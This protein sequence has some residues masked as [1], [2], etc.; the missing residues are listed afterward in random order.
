[1]TST[2]GSNFTLA[3]PYLRWA[4][5]GTAIP[6]LEVPYGTAW[7]GSWVEFTDTVSGLEVQNRNPRDPVFTERLERIGSVPAAAGGGGGRGR[8]GGRGGGGGG[9][10]GGRG[11]G[12]GG[13]RG[14]AGQ[15]AGTSVGFQ[16]V[17]LVEDFWRISNK[18]SKFTIAA[19]PQIYS[20]TF[21]T[22]ATS[23]GNLT[24][25]LEGVTYTLP[26]TSASHST[27]A[28]V[29]TF[30]RTGTNWSP[31][32]P[33]AGPTGFTLGGTGANV[34]LQYGTN[35]Y[36]R[37]PSTTLPY[38]NTFA[39][40]GTGVTVSTGDPSVTQYGHA[41]VHSNWV[42]R[43]NEFHFMLGF[44]AKFVAGSLFPVDTHIRGVLFR[45]ENTM[46]GRDIYGWN[47]RDAVIDADVTCEAIPESFVDWP[48]L[49]SQLSKSGV[50]E[51]KVDQQK[52]FMLLDMP[53]V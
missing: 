7:G 33:A 35:I 14:T 25:T 5:R 49:F 10:G 29:A 46:D 42:D 12:G 43:S 52:R 22:G 45:A 21:L 51:A 34:T 8:G 24:M 6:G 26:V 9:G 44:D 28:A 20:L 1:M 53:L 15:G 30:A 39:A 23:N 38:V 27:P 18:F 31:V 32:L 41:G 13:G 16:I 40:G 19:Q 17:H 37:D 2:P 36:R 11:G 4:P 47:G 48:N 50:T 3:Q